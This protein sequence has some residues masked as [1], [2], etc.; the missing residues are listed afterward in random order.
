MPA[1]VELGV[2]AAVEPAAWAGTH[3]S[4][5]ESCPLPLATVASGSA[6]QQ[7]LIMYVTV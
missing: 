2:R 1:G 4:V 3:R 6:T 5:F 7:N